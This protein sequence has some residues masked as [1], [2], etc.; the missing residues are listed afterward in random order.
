MFSTFKCGHGKIV[1]ENRSSRQA[2]LRKQNWIQYLK[3]KSNST[4]QVG[5]LEYHI[6]FVDI[7]SS[8][9]NKCLKMG[10]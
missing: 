1:L 8:S 2:L 3:K 9:V 6:L 4:A 7:F 10:M 5:M